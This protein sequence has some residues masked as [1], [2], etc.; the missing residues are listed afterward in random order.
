MEYLLEQG[1]YEFELPL[2]ALFFYLLVRRWESLNY[3]DK[4]NK[5]CKRDVTL[6]HSRQRTGDNAAL[7]ESWN[8]ILGPS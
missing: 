3:A 1:L 6:T 7:P 2:F 8:E 5:L 4:S